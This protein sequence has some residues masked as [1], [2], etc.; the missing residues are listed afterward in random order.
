MENLHEYGAADD[1]AEVMVI[2]REHGP[3]QA[4]SPIRELKSAVLAIDWE[5]TDSILLRFD[6]EVRELL[7]VFRDDIYC[8]KLLQILDVVGRYIRSKQADAHP[9]SIGILHSSY[10]VLEEFVTGAGSLSDTYKTERVTKVITAFNKLKTAVRRSSSGDE[11]E[12]SAQ[13]QGQTATE[14]P[15]E[16]VRNQVPEI[17]IR[18]VSSTEITQVIS[19]KYRAGAQGD[20]A[21]ESADSGPADV[22]LDFS[23]LFLMIKGLVQ[24]EL[25]AFKQELLEEITRML[26][27]E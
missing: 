6:E 15:P 26:S 14:Q 9:L 5:I 25:T 16:P 20:V 1:S 19:H 10:D 4:N 23:A 27:K 2:D 21:R 17:P 22:G 12:A 18:P 24:E 11:S 13:A 3:D 8:V 7:N